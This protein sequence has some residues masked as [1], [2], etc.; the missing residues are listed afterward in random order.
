[1]E[2]CPTRSW[3]DNDGTDK[4][5]RGRW[6]KLAGIFSY[7]IRVA[8][9]AAFSDRHS[10]EIIALPDARITTDR[11]HS[12]P[13]L[14]LFRHYR[15]FALSLWHAW[16]RRVL[17]RSRTASFLFNHARARPSAP[18][19]WKF[20]I[21][22][23]VFIPPT[24]GPSEKQIPG[25]LLIFRARPPFIRLIGNENVSPRLVER[26]KKKREERRGRLSVPRIMRASSSGD[27]EGRKRVFFSFLSCFLLFS[28]SSFFFARSRL[29]ILE[30]VPTCIDSPE[31]SVF[32]CG[33]FQ[34][35][36]EIRNLGL[37]V[38]ARLFG[39]C[40]GLYRNGG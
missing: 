18:D 27:D 25:C 26:G 16:P 37:C 33:N 34:C 9:R 30:L 21:P 29:R 15:S 20:L 32:H 12:I 5:G 4:D 35:T 17:A 38:R 28:S 10:S 11:L 1:M 40:S 6:Q 39:L 2:A 14:F 23:D 13:L 8:N 24:R 22:G 19:L 31:F 36:A 3:Y 7:E